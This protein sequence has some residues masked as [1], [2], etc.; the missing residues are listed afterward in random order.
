MENIGS[1][2]FLVIVAV[3]LVLVLAIR[4]RVGSRSSFAPWVAKT[5]SSPDYI[6]TTR[7]KEDEAIELARDRPPKDLA[8]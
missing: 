7:A 4:A 3:L 8:P 1:W 2:L 6:N 5:G